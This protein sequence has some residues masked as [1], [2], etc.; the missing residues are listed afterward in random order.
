MALARTVW[1]GA[2]EGLSALTQMLPRI[3]WDEA[4]EHEWEHK[5]SPSG[6]PYK[7]CQHCRTTATLN[8]RELWSGGH[9]PGLI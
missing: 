2:A 1:I 9:R 4:C 5:E 3:S 6:K 7:Q 8:F